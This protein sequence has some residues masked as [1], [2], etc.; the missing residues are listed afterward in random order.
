MTLRSNF[1]M[2]SRLL[3][4]GFVLPVGRPHSPDRPRIEFM[5]KRGRSAPAP[6]CCGRSHL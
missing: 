2:R 4:L 5:P 3:D 1:Y 6:A